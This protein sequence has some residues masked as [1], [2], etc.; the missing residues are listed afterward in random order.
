MRV[1]TVIGRTGVYNNVLL[2]VNRNGSIKELKNII[3]SS[4]SL[5]TSIKAFSDEYYINGQFSD[6]LYFDD[7]TIVST[8]NTKDVFLLKKAVSS[9]SQLF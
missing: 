9:F 1:L 8:N 2:K 7:K 4:T 3:S 5:F 6:T